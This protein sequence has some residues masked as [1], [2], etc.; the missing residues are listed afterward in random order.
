M[1]FPIDMYF[2]SR[3]SH[4][5]VQ[6]KVNFDSAVKH[7]KKRPDAETAKSPKPADGVTIHKVKHGDTAITLGN[8]HGYR[9]EQ[10]QLMNPGLRENADYLVE[11]DT[12]TILD[13][14]LFDT[15]KAS[16]QLTDE[17]VTAERSYVKMT[18]NDADTPAHVRK[19]YAMEAPSVKRNAEE[20]RGE[21][22]AL[23]TPALLEAA[24]PSALDKSAAD[25]A[26]DAHAAAIAPVG[27]DQP[28]F[29]KIVKAAK[30]D[31]RTTIDEIFERKVSFKDGATGE[32]RKADLRELV[33]DAKD[34]PGG[35]HRRDPSLEWQNVNRGMVALLHDLS[36][37]ATT[38]DKATQKLAETQAVRNIAQI[39]GAASPNQDLAPEVDPFITAVNSAADRVLVQS[40]VDA[41]YAAAEAR[42]AGSVPALQ[43]L[44][45]QTEGIDMPLTL[46]RVEGSQS[47][48]DA[49]LLDLFD[50]SITRGSGAVL[51]DLARVQSAMKDLTILAD[52]MPTTE[53]E[54]GVRDLA[55]SVVRII[56]KV[57]EKSDSSATD[58]T[59]QISG[60]LRDAIAS[61]Q[62]PAL[63]K[64]IARQ[65]MQKDGGRPAHKTEA[66]IVLMGAGLGMEKLK[67]NATSTGEEFYEKIVYVAE[68][69]RENIGES[70]T[71]SHAAGVD[72]LL[73]SEKSLV[74][75]TDHYGKA[76]VLTA[77]ATQDLPKELQGLDGAK[78]VKTAA[79]DL[80]DGIDQ[81][82]VSGKD[83]K[84]KI[85]FL[86][87]LRQYSPGAAL[88]SQQIAADQARTRLQDVPGE[89]MDKLV[90]E[91]GKV[92]ADDPYHEVITQLKSLDDPKAALYDSP[93]L[94]LALLDRFSQ[95]DD[96][97]PDEGKGP[98]AGFLSRT[99]RD[100]LLEVYAF[101]T[102]SGGGLIPGVKPIQPN[103]EVRFQAMERSLDV[104][105]RRVGEDAAAARSGSPG[106]SRNGFSGLTDTA[107]S[108]WLKANPIRTL[109]ARG[110][111]AAHAPAIPF[112]S[113]GSALLNGWG[114]ATLTQSDVL[115]DQAWGYYFGIGAARD[116]ALGYNGLRSWGSG[117][118]GFSQIR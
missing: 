18:T 100:V 67:K 42:D 46:Q 19:L 106:A 84:A 60:G 9:L 38:G 116:V 23:L 86:P 118:P 87:M 107:R 77:A 35:S 61:G 31:A 91:L 6:P 40:P 33:A 55:S 69:G 22:A 17:A 51:P 79:E 8:G 10:L 74:D 30:D 68:V 21:A 26:L 4:P 39:L 98:N 1:G 16:V 65:L 44:V 27:D 112:V 80:R 75:R 45:K 83:E 104:A 97:R 20:K 28:E 25:K 93:E 78:N 110:G 70:N 76:V 2:R 14:G 5:Y 92:P 117:K 3:I 85:N 36:L 73:K 7:A 101:Q 58:V 56:D 94:T 49:A 113:A 89:D 11:G 54:E 48:V 29:A 82:L 59:A 43:E 109:E 34:T 53:G 37:E 111:I 12:L 105:L 57:G 66:S 64:E 103:S 102:Q 63:A 114:T 99:G 71:Y 108:L 13:R 62:S 95:R 32:T 15:V 88:A 41:V 52:R 90:G 24:L 96:A 50:Q 72:S 115:M 81:D 47:A